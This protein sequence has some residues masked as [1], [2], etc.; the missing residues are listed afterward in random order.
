[1]LSVMGKKP[2]AKVVKKKLITDEKLSSLPQ[3]IME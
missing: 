3:I 2:M 1:M